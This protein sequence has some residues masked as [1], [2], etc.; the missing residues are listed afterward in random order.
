MKEFVVEKANNNKGVVSLLRKEF[1]KLNQN[2]IFKALRNKDIRINDARIKE[3]T[4]VHT[5][6]RIKVFISDD[7]LFGRNSFFDINEKD[8]A[9]EDDNILIYNKPIGVEVQ[10]N[11]KEMGIEEALKDYYHFDYIKACHRLD[12]NTCGL[13]IFAK[14]EKS[15]SVMLDAIKKHQV[16][17][18]YKAH[19]YGN[20][21][22]KE[23]TLIAYLFKDSKKSTVIISDSPK[24]GYS[25]IITKYKLLKKYKDGSSLLEVEIITGKTHQIRAHLA[26]VGLPIIGDGKY[27]LNEINKAY[28][29]KFQDLQSFKLIFEIEDEE[30]KYLNDL[31]IEV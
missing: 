4:I 19:V 18:F 20:V 7:L 22:N 27:G 28:S 2:T 15:E 5:G 16:R 30:F 6:D 10:G 24:K 3:D 23:N 14:N 26:H 25:K 12:R 21:T 13:V 17:K 8:V 11:A 31:V 29:K 9:Y 1:P